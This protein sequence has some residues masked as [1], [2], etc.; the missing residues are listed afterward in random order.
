MKKQ[1]LA[2]ALALVSLF[3]S[4][5]VNAQTTGMNFIID[6]CNGNPHELFA[7]L[8]AGKVVIIEFFMTSCGSCV[9]AGD[10]LETMKADLLVEFP[11]MI[12]SYAFGYTNSYSCATVNAWVTT[13]GFTSVPSDSGAAQVAYYG[14]FGMPTIVVLGGA[15]THDILGTPYIGFST[16]DTTTM[17][18]DIRGFFNGF[19]GIADPITSVNNVSVYPNPANNTVN[20]SLTFATTSDLVIEV[21]DLTGRVVLNVTNEKSQ[22]GSI[23]R[24]IN[25]ADI[26]EGNYLVRVNVGGTISHEKLAVV[27]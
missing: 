6:D 4:Q 11:G 26:A 1:L 25:T 24:T 8:D 23:I 12:K 18:N 16:S 3:A 17:A 13:N 27:H 5:N 22:S 7:D 14:G 21:V 15:T 19:A 10:K 20:I 2:V 9:V